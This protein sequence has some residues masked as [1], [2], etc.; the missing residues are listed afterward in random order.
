MGSVDLIVIAVLRVLNVPV[1]TYAWKW[2]FGSA[3]E[4][5]DRVKFWLTPDILSMLRGEYWRDYWSE[6]KLA[7]WILVCLAPP[8]I[9]WWAIRV[10]LVDRV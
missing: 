7:L 4:F 3:E 6:L 5:W 10:L 1:A 2:I 8:A 9:G